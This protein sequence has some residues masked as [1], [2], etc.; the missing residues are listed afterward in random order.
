MGGGFLGGGLA[1]FL[2]TIFKNHWKSFKEKCA[3]VPPKK[4]LA[5]KLNAKFIFPN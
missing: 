4:L 5:K 2:S 1:G 3:Q